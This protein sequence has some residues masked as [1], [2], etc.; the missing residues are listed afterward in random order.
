MRPAASTSIMIASA[1]LSLLAWEA[2]SRSGIVPRALFPSPSDVTAAMVDW[3]RNGA[4]L[5]DLAS[6]A[7]RA[8]AGYTIGAAIGVG[9]GVVSGRSRAVNAALA[10]LLHALRPVPPVAVIPLVILW[11][12]IDDAAKISA[13]AFAVFFPV[14][15]AAHTASRSTPQIY[16]WSAETLGVGGV[17]QLWK[18]VLPASLPTIVAGLRIGVSTAFIMVFVTELAGASTGLGYQI[19]ASQTAYRV[20][21]MMAALAVLTA[22]AALADFALLAVL[23]RA[24]PWL[25]LAET[26]S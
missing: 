4:I 24:F 23:R 3:A 13:T 21:R 19:A 14:W 17:E 22:L 6:S 2:V 12:G 18:V 15:I 1:V 5:V 10:P 8:L 25:R 7:W 26:S 11:L 20:D 16:L 9:V